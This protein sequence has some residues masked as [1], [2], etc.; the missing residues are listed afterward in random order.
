MHKSAKSESALNLLGSLE[1]G[2]N[3]LLFYDDDK[4]LERFLFQYV[5]TGL[6]KGETVFY[7]AGIQT[8]EEAERKML[9]YGIDCNYY[10]RNG[11]L[12]FTSYDDMV[13]V[14]G[15]LDLLNCQRNLL[16]MANTNHNG[17]KIRLATESN[18]WLLADVFENGLDM[19]TAHEIV[20]QNISIVCSYNIANLM[21]YVSIYH[22][23]KLMELHNYTLVETKGSVMLPLEFYSYLGKCILDILEDSFEYITIVRSKHSRFISEVLSELEMRIGSDILELERRVEEKLGQTLKL[24]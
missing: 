3:A 15:R 17:N 7:W 9:R 23:A 14:D 24:A 10:K 13:L 22:L 12:R 20:P 8:V 11:T 1:P 2:K 5:K 19:E 21:K 4:M 6:Q 16:N 18:W